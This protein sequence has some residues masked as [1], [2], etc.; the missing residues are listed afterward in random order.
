MGR[1]ERAGRRPAHRVTPAPAARPRRRRYLGIALLAVVPAAV[2]LLVVLLDPFPASE[3]AAAGNEP[4]AA[5]GSA[6]AAPPGN[7]PVATSGS[8]P[9]A[10][11]GVGTNTPPAP[12]A[13]VDRDTTVA[14]VDG[15]PLTAGQ[16]RRAAQRLRAEIVAELPAAAGPHA[17]YWTT[18]V[19][20]GT[21]HDV[22]LDRAVRAAVSEQVLRWWAREAGLSTDAT[23]SAF[24]TRLD[25]E[26]ARRAAAANAG[27]PEPGVPRYD[28]DGFARTEQAELAG[29]LRD[30][31][32]ARVDL[33]EARLRARHAELIAAAGPATA[34][35]FEQVRD[36]V[37]RDILTTEFD[38]ELRT[39]VAAA[40]TEILPAASLTVRQSE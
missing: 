28:E 29:A 35:P 10:P 38:R 33:S 13:P 36:Q 25:A 34:P 8:A 30:S 11:P 14:L 23:E 37:R 22:L 17:G 19:A 12:P 7:A 32:T 5:F 9:T 31:L 39:R 6:P 20:G 1:R 16:L 26:N 24:R 2:G 40:R 18:P 4:A 27:R 21:P 15:S 3:R